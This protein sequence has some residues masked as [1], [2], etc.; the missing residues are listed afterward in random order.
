MLGRRVVA[1][2]PTRRAQFIRDII[3]APK[4]SARCRHRLN[5]RLL[6]I[7]SG[8]ID[9]VPCQ[10]C[11]CCTRLSYPWR[12][13]CRIDELG[14]A[15]TS[16]NMLSRAKPARPLAAQILIFGRTLDPPAPP[17]LRLLQIR[18]GSSPDAPRTTSH[19]SRQIPPVTLCSDCGSVPQLDEAIPMHSV[20]RPM[21]STR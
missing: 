19:R 1:I 7:Y 16:L 15:S 18:S 4:N 20:I 13:E 9:Q 21:S 6:Y 14:R 8:R 10:R 17:T 12:E 2:N 11:N 5:T 3:A